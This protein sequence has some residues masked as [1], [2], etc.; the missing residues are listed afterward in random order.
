MKM[1]SAEQAAALRAAVLHGETEHLQ[2][3]VQIV[4]NSGALDA[5]REAARKET[6][7]AAECLSCLPDNE[8]TKALLKFA[9][10]SVGRSS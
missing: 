1:G 9:I 4:R 7:W 2:D 3:I 5:T 8:W 10:R 6:Q